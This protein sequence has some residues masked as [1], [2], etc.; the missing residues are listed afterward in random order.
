MVSLETKDSLEGGGGGLQSKSSF[1][2]ISGDISDSSRLQEDFNN[3]Y[4]IIPERLPEYDLVST[5]MPF[6]N[7]DYWKDCFAP[8][9][10]GA[11]AGLFS[12]TLEHAMIAL[13]VLISASADNYLGLSSSPSSTTTSS[14]NFFKDVDNEH[15]DLSTKNKSV[16][17][18]F[19]TKF[20]ANPLMFL[21]LESVLD[22]LKNNIFEFSNTPSAF[23]EKSILFQYGPIWSCISLLKCLRASLKY[24]MDNRIPPASLGLVLVSEVSETSHTFVE[25]LFRHAI[26]LIASSTNL[27]N[28]SGKSIEKFISELESQSYFFSRDTLNKFV[29]GLNLAALDTLVSG[30][31]IFNPNEEERLAVLGNLMSLFSWNDKLDA[32]KFKYSAKQNKLS[33]N[34]NFLFYA[35]YLLQNICNEVA[36]WDEAFINKY[37]SSLTFSGKFSDKIIRET[38]TSNILSK[39]FDFGS[40]QDKKLLFAFLKRLSFSEIMYYELNKNEKEWPNKFLFWGEFLL[41]RNLQKKIFLAYES[42]IE[43]PRFDEKRCHS[44]IQISSDGMSA[45]HTNAKAWVTVVTSVG[46]APCTGVHEWTV[47]IN[48]CEKGHIFVGIVTAE[49][50]IETYI[51]ELNIHII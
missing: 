42:H 16:T 45:T 35:N 30:F 38:N 4:P 27:I 36:S 47:Q 14:C 26:D 20:S 39:E 1:P 44:S 28:P 31:F 29:H 23:D 13:L 22:S 11:G 6:S 41:L 49:S 25:N 19:S 18:F 17:Y 37:N 15:D 12:V 24:T 3:V 51:G 48:K 8:E 32:S 7:K 40:P 46:Y 33:Q 9:G 5:L 10:L 50:S 2:S 21:L 43:R 34:D